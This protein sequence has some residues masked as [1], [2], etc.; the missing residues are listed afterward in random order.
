M[1]VGRENAR[2]LKF[3]IRS[4]GLRFSSSAVRVEDGDHR[5]K[6]GGEVGGAFS[7][8]RTKGGFGKAFTG[9]ET[10]GCGVVGFGLC[11]ACV[12]FGLVGESATR[13]RGSRGRVALY[14]WKY[15]RTEGSGADTPKS[16]IEFESD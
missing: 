4:G 12:V 2:K 16:F 7:R 6:S 10:L 8:S 14:K 11:S 3:H 13:G 9:G 1:C 5:Q 15:W